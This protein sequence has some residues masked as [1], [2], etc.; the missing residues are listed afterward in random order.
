MSSPTPPT[1]P[2]K[3]RKISRI[4]ARSFAAFLILLVLITAYVAFV[5]VRIDAGKYRNTISTL[6]SEKLGRKIRFDGDLQLELS[7]HPATG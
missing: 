1:A 6:L 4:T 3:A 7:L 2:D 5:G